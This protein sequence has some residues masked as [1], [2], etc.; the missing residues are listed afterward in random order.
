M[1]IVVLEA[2]TK[3]APYQVLRVTALVAAGFSLIVAI[4]MVANYVS[5]NR[6]DPVHSPALAKLLEQLKANPRDA[7]LREEIREL[8][9]LTRQ[10]FFTSQH[11]T[12]VALALLVGGLTVMVICYKTLNAYRAVPPYPDSSDPKT[13]LAASALWARKSVTAVGLVLLGFALV[14][15]LP[16]R[17]PL[18]AP[19]AKT[20]ATAPAAPKAAPAAPAATKTAAPVAA[21]PST[22]YASLEER[23]AQ[24]PSFRGAGAGLSRAGKV[25]TAWDPEKGAAWKSEVALP[26]MNSPVVW[27]D[28]V[29]L[30]GAD[31][32]SR[33]IYCYQAATGTLRWKQALAPLTATAK[34]TLK[35]ADYTGYAASTMATDGARVFAIFVDG[36]VAAFTVDGQPAWQRS[37][38][39]PENAYGYASSLVAFEDLLIVQVDRKNDSFVI[40]I[41]AATGKDRWK[42]PRQFGPSWSSPQVVAGPQGPLLLT[43]ANPCVVAYDPRN[44]KELWRVECLK[45]AEAAVSPGYADGVLYAAAEASGLT[46]IEVATKKVLWK[47]EEG[48]PGICTPLVSHGWLFYGLTDGGI[49]CVDAK[50]G[51]ELWRQDTDDGIFASPVL[52]GENVYL[53]DHVGKVHIFKAQGNAYQAVGTGVVGEEVFATPAVVG[54]GL[55]IRGVKNLYRFGS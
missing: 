24:W 11:F 54:H 35:V 49:L 8:D 40:G 27:N 42:T 43:A 12:H 9:L 33:E 28:A 52:V 18:D 34:K 4:L 32:N 37:L 46:A 3:S 26:G 53:V 25:P 6:L 7:A 41:D 17:S 30:S 10:A 1:R 20:P 51:K 16:W 15:A 36:E 47:K 5:V 39:L 45:D 44:G 50:T 22:T 21:A 23:L 19:P 14:L 2:D 38:G 48:V 55:F 29:F 31:T 13:D